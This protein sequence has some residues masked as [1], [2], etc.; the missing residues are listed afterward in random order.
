M[1]S[2]AIKASGMVTAV[3]FNA[4]ASLAALRAG[5]RNVNETNLW[6]AGSGTYLSA[7]K[8][9]LPHWWI[10]LGKLAELV[11][12]AILEC[13]KAADPVP[14]H[15]IPVLLGVAPPVRPFRFRDLDG[16]ILGEIEDRLGFGLH[17]TSRVI[18]QDHVS[19]AVGLRE[20][21]QLI[22]GGKA[23]CV[24]V[25]AVDSLVRQDLVEHYLSRRRLLSPN[26]SNGFSVGEAGTAVLVVPGGAGAEGELQVL[27]IGMAHERATIDSD[28]PVRADGLTRAIR[29]AF[30]EAGLTILDV[31]FRITDLNGEH[32]KFKEMALAMMRFER[33]PKPKLFDL[34]HPIEFVGDVGAAIGPLVLAHALHA[35]RKGYGNGPNAL[36]TL[37]DEDGG[38]AALVVRYEP[39]EKHP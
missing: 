19:V 30:G 18:A 36:C 5:L 39:G 17:P 20:A 13:F 8:V 29:D 34:W 33:K 22:V 9:S 11:A 14:P 32:Y 25:G 2:I 15:E 26:N 10:G 35:G 27:G 24:I 4:A 12:P 7:G 1:P 23:R 3:G 6:D 37:S 28:E 21:E 16:R 38:R 31:Q